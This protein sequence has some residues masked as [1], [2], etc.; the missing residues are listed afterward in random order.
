MKG[1]IVSESEAISLA[2]Q[3]IAPSL[4][5]SQRRADVWVAAKCL[6]PQEC[7]WN[8]RQFCVRFTGSGGV[9]FSG[10]H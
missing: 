10:M 9:V 3:G 4:Q 5:G 7:C 2:L 1:V 6:P 8:K